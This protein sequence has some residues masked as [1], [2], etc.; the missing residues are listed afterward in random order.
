MSLFLSRK[1]ELSIGV[2]YINGS[3]QSNWSASLAVNW[4]FLKQTLDQ[5]IL[6]DWYVEVLDVFSWHSFL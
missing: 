4:N 6:S 5:T 3:L 2:V 1:K